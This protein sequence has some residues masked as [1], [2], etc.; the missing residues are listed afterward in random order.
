MLHPVLRPLDLLAVLPGKLRQVVHRRLQE[1]GKGGR[2]QRSIGRDEAA[3]RLQQGS[4]EGDAPVTGFVR[5]CGVPAP[6]V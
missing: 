6:P 1:S 3:L 4:R 2:L 5:S